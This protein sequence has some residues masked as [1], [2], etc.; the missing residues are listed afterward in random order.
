[1]LLTTSPDRP[2]PTPLSQVSPVKLC[3]FNLG[4]PARAGNVT[5]PLTTPVGTPEYMAPEVLE[6]MEA[7]EQ[8]HYDKRCDIWSLGIILYIMLCGYTPFDGDCG[9]DCGWKRGEQCENCQVCWRQRVCPRVLLF[10]C[11]F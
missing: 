2:L 3:D 4:T 5:P 1:M 8:A 11:V 10:F 9:M 6:T 7:G